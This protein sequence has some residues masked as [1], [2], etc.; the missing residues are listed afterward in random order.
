MQRG[1]KLVED[2]PPDAETVRLLAAI[3]TG[4]WGIRVPRDWG[5]AERYARRA[6]DMA[7]QLNAPAEICSALNALGYVYGGRGLFRESVQIELTRLTL[8]QDPRFD[9]K[10]ERVNILNQVGQALVSVGEYAQALPHLLEAERLATQ[11][12]DLDQQITCLSEQSY[13]LYQMDR[14]DQTIKIEDKWRA[15]LRRFPSL[16]KLVSGSCWQMSL[17]ASVHI[18]RGE[19][20]EAAVLRDDS[21][22]IMLDKY[23]GSEDRFERAAYY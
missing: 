11:V 19:F 8:S 14:W 10:H 15:L 12:Q 13:C 1:L 3:S 22:A 6:V 17:N 5:S 2:Q 20:K 16:F 4:A 9:D 18:R 23:Y 21:Y 7:E